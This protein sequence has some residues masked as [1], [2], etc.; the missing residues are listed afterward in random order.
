MV[1]KALTPKIPCDLWTKLGSFG[2]N[3]K[4]PIT[5]NTLGVIRV[6]HGVHNIFQKQEGHE[7]LWAI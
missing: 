7:L 2:H 3:W 6:P 1:K 5:L 4:N